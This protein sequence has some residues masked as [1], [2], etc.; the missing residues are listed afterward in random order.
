MLHKNP[1]EE[2]SEHHHSSISLRKL[3]A[4]P[5][6]ALNYGLALC[7]WICTSLK[8]AASSLPL[9]WSPETHA[10]IFKPTKVLCY[11]WAQ[12]TLLSSG[13]PLV[14]EAI[15]YGVW[16]VM[17]LSHRLSL[18]AV[19]ELWTWVCKEG[20][21]RHQST[22]PSLVLWRSQSSSNSVLGPQCIVVNKVVKSCLQ[23]KLLSLIA[24]WKYQSWTAGSHQV[25][26][27]SCKPRV[28]SGSESGN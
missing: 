14:F 16:A 1:S 7:E 23:R 10:S 5:D 21:R 9:I 18:D 13:P 19:F 3:W 28:K 22:V 6:I 4:G 8:L 2:F 25:R 24:V 11:I 15:I 17:A 20:L 12:E 26:A 27:R